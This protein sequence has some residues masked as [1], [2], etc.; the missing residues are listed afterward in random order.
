MF[1]KRQKQDHCRIHFQSGV[2]RGSI[3][4]ILLRYKHFL[5]NCKSVGLYEGN[6]KNEDIFIFVTV[7]SLSI[8]YFH[9]TKYD[10]AKVK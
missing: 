2:L 10:R 9:I 3:Q 8:Y 4:Q 7:V 1:P 5:D 6:M